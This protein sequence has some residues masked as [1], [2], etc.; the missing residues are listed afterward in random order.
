MWV[1]S[2]EL[3]SDRWVDSRTHPSRIKIFRKDA[4]RDSRCWN[5]PACVTHLEKKNSKKNKLQSWVTPLDPDIPGFS[6]GNEMV[7]LS[8]ELEAPQE[9]QKIAYDGQAHWSRRKAWWVQPPC[10]P[11]IIDPSPKQP[12]K[13]DGNNSNGDCNSRHPPYLHHALCCVISFSWA[14]G[15]KRPAFSF[16]SS[17]GDGGE[18]AWVSTFILPL[19]NVAVHLFDSFSTILGCICL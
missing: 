15:F 16:I 8:Q 4:R 18:G 2:C 1:N 10:V 6:L 7:W 9:V 13:G 19:S 17:K 12:H 14:R 11:S 5:G 3:D